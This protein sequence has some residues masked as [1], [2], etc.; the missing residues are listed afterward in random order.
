MRKILA[1]FHCME[2]SSAEPW[3]YLVQGQ[4]VT[5]CECGSVVCL[6]LMC[7]INANDT[8]KSFTPRTSNINTTISAVVTLEFP[9][10]VV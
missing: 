9:R 5:C 1:N 2:S 3:P 6:C 7:G 8:L 4:R 10:T